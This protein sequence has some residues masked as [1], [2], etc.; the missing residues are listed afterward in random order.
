[1]IVGNREDDRKALLERGDY[2]GE[3]LWGRFAVDPTYPAAVLGAPA[4]GVAHQ[5]ID[6]SGGDAGVFQPSREGVPQ[7]M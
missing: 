1:L 5:L 3:H 7:V 6:H 4:T 2:A